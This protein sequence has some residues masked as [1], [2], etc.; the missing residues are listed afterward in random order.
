MVGAVLAYQAANAFDPLLFAL[1]FVGIVFFHLATN[2]FNDNFDFRSGNDLAV[3]HQNPFAGG[4]RVLITGRIG[5]N[6][7]L[8][9]ASTI[10]AAATVI[11]L[12]IFLLMGGLGNP[13]AQLLLVIGAVG[14]I[15]VLFYVAPPV[16]LANWG[17]GELVVGLCFGPLVVVGA[18][19]VQ[20]RTVT[21]GA[22]LLSISM[23][24]LVAAILWINE[25]PDVS[26]D[27]SVGKKT[28]MARLGPERSIG[29]YNG[30]VATA[31]VMPVVGAALRVVPSMALLSLLSIPL[32]WRAAKGLRANYRDPHDLIPANAGTVSLTVVF[33]ILLMVGVALGIWIPI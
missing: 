10:F 15:A 32:A 8:A 1:S 18:Y 25:F 6:A 24:L 14:W 21:P 11:G 12:L 27:L 20:T 5:V 22:I 17:V 19:L 30:L 33:G 31:F 28:L 29:V 13:A 7:H 4:G 16:R 3:E 26:A 9:A 2:M 23:G